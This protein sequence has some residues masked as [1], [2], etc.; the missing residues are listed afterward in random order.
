MI[1]LIIYRRA[2]DENKQTNKKHC[3]ILKTLITYVRAYRVMNADQIF[4]NINIIACV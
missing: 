3:D 4:F 2:N 1:K